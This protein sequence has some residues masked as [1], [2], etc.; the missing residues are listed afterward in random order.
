MKQ[1]VDKEINKQNHSAMNR[2]SMKQTLKTVFL[3]AT[4]VFAGNLALMAQNETGTN[5]QVKIG[6]EGAASSTIEKAKVTVKGLV[7][8][9]E[10]K[11]V[12]NV[13][14][15][16]EGSRDMPAFSDENG[17]FEL[18]AYAGNV[19]L[20][21]A[22]A[23]QYKRKRIF[24]GGRTSLTIMLTPLGVASGEDELIVLSQA[25]SRKNMPSSFSD[26]D[27]SNIQNTIVPSIDRYFQGRIA[28]M[29]V[30][31]Q[32]GAPGAGATTFIRG[33]NSLNATNQPLFIVDGAIME[34]Q[35]MFG[36]IVHGYNYNPLVSVNPFD[37]SNLTVI[38]DAD[39]A[40]AYGSKASNG[41]IMISTLD[42]SATETS[43]EIDLRR[44]L[45]LKPSQY[46]PQLNAA[47]HKTLANELLY[48]SG[49]LEED[50]IEN[51]P[52]VFL[53]P[54]METFINY[55]HDTEWQQYIFDN[56]SFT[57]F[58]IKVKG[59]DEIARYGLS[60]GYYNNNGILKNTKYD[61]YNIRFVSLV[62]IF[63]WLRMNATV[64]F[65]TS[66]SDLKES[67][68]VK[69]TSPILSSLAKSPLLNPYQ[70]DADDKETLMLSEVDEFGV[71]NPLATIENF[72]A[73][74]KNYNINTSLGFEAD[75]G[76]D[77]VMTTNIG[78]LYNSLKEKMFMPNKGMELY[79]D[80]EAHN[81]AKASTNTFNGFTNNTMLKY[82]KQIGNNH[83]FTS[84]TGFNIMTNKFQY[85]WGIAKNAHE[86]DEYRMLADGIDNLREIGG[87]N[88]NWN[89]ASLY[90]KVT[91][92]FQDRFLFSGTVSLDASS[93]IGK[94]AIN[95][96]K[97]LGNPF[98]LFYSTGLGWRVSNESF[99]DD[100]AW[101]E[102]LK[103]RA[104]YGR[105]GN[106]D[107]GEANASNFLQTVHYRSTSGVIPATIPNSYLSYET[108]DKLNTGIDLAL[109]G[110]RVRVNFDLY[111]TNVS[112]MLL[113]IPLEA[114]IGYDFRPENNG[115]MQNRG[116]DLYTFVRIVNSRNFKWDVEATLS[117]VNNQV[118]EIENDKFVTTLNSYELVNQVGEAANSFYGYNFLG[119]YQTTEEAMAAN[120]VNEKGVLYRAGDAKY[121]D[122]SGPAGTPDGMINDFD[123]MVIGNPFPEMIGG[124]TNTF[125]YRNFTLSAF[126]NFVSGNE[127]YNYLRY[128]NESMTD[129]HN[130]SSH[131]LNRWQYEGQQTDVPRAMW[132]DPVGNSDF[133]TRWI[134]DG[135]YL[136]LKNVSLSYRIP[137][138]FLA[139]KYA[140]F[141]I[142]ATN[143]LTLSNYLGYDPEFSNSFS[144]LDQGIDYGQSPHPRQFL[145]GIKIGL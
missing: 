64:S 123:K 122:I 106:D 10:N 51:Y 95:T 97:L 6:E 1:K 32:S 76:E 55:Q 101:L 30:V 45:S 57:N 61:G 115:K 96:I 18:T 81:V 111:N 70:Y 67:A 87:E 53:E 71:S 72:E 50:L 5:Q 3:A 44:G 127:M 116:W 82:K 136:R 114:Y 59:G 83:L 79:Y 141:Y 23:N 43:F 52:N 63:T 117:S 19:W 62:N 99:L 75:L 48:T 29:H 47:Q 128:K 74:N 126:V 104:S 112:N 118:T 113:Y 40:A 144:I 35:G 93:R 133:S 90:E 16:V 37:I 137:N 85:D 86:N 41:L 77:F 98:G 13:S 9:P 22:P 80:N 124:L 135:S 49:M 4:L 15:S 91:Y 100:V 108:V 102:E 24:L 119:V 33:I 121:E 69:E 2:F 60:F 103:I 132:N 7:V 66:N 36:S 78:I 34:P 31:N 131:T 68:I 8:S 107:I 143:L 142:S 73:N 26:L 89:W 42:P 92:A 120:L 139:F 88:R 109:L 11:P 105:T 28:G 138:E 134:E 27:V 58:N 25:V 14:I 65:V 39:Y 20:S 84:T 21:V 125:K 46:I 94:D 129:L 145:V 38:K 130:Q 17:E 12:A 56:A 54:D 140:E 110:N